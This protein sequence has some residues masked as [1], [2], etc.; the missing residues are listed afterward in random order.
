MRT[1]QRSSA[2]PGTDSISTPSKFDSRLNVTQF[3]LGKLPLHGKKQSV[4]AQQLV[5]AGNHIIE[6][7]KGPRQDYV[8]ARLWPVVLDSRLYNP[9]IVEIQSGNRLGQETGFLAV[10]VQ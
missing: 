2:R 4:W 3:I 8:K 7:C 10:A 6:G 5:A 9:D 1:R